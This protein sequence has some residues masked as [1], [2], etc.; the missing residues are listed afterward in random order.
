MTNLRKKTVTIELPSFIDQAI[1]FMRSKSGHAVVIVV[2]ALLLCTLTAMLFADVMQAIRGWQLF[3]VI[4]GVLFALGLEFGIFFLAIN[5]YNT[6]SLICAAFSVAIARATFAQLFAADAVDVFVYSS[7]T[8]LYIAS[9][10]MSLFPPALVAFVSHK[11]AEK[12]AHEELAYQ[13]IEDRETGQALG[14]SQKNISEKKRRPAG[15]LAS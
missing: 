5:G 8:P 13:V 3:G 12:F 2:M 11:L 6:A 14:M 15:Q 10:V 1:E 9:W 4:V 7:W